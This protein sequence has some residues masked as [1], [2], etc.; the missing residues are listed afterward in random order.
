MNLK[1]H[2]DFLER[3]ESLE[4]KLNISL[5]NITQSIKDDPK[6][7]HCENLIGAV[8]IPVGVAGPLKIIGRNSKREF[9]VPLATTE[10]ALV[11]SVNRGCKAITQSGGTTVQIEEVGVTRGPIFKV[12]GINQALWF[13]EWLNKNFAELKTVAEATSSHLKLKKIDTSILGKNVYVRFYFDTDFAMGMNM[14]T[15][16]TEAIV[17]YIGVKTKIACLALAG[18]F[19]IDKKAA[20][21]NFISGRGRR[22]WAEVVIPK[23]ILKYVLKTDAETLNEV[24]QSKCW[25]GSMMSGSLGF[26]AHFA[27][28]AAAFFAATGQDLAH[29]VEASLGITSAEVTENKGLYVSVYLPDIMMGTVGGG[30]N[31][32]TQSE[33][34]SIV[35]V[36]TLAELS[37]VFAGAVLAGEISLLSSIAQQSLARVHK[38]LGR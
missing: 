15:L 12:S 5:V 25:G 27:N 16:A 23:S 32:K 2:N 38:E 20:W 28:I 4:K 1:A 6:N 24:I 14:A 29:V 13:K 31:L 26:N 34:H 30:T 17:K 21:L 18:N 22:A 8:S 36:K 19:D 7:I 3:A 37:E 35:G 33:A 10:G 9:F 11:A